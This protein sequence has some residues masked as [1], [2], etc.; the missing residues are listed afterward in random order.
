MSTVKTFDRVLKVLA[1]NYADAFL[2][3]ALPD[4]PLKLAG[5]LENVELSIPEERVDF[6]HRVLRGKQ[7]YLLHI[8]FQ[9]THR[10]DVPQ[11]LFVYSALL[12]KQMDT[13]VITIVIYLTPRGKSLPES[14]DVAVDDLVLNRFEYQVVRLWEYR[15][16]I[17]AGRWPELAPL[18]AMLTPEPD[19]RVLARE[20]ELILK[21]SDRRKRADLLACAVTIGTRYFDREFLWRFFREEVEMMKEATFIDDWLQE[22]LNEGLTRGRLE[23]LQEGLQVGYRDGQRDTSRSILRRVLHMRFGEVMLPLDVEEKLNLLPPSQLEALIYEA[24][25]ASDE[26]S[27]FQAVREAGGVAMQQVN[28]DE[29]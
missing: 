16:E 5:T 26:E 18:L 20:R 8:E 10:A 7:E 14:Y 13:P 2:R 17:E 28:W 22:K 1:R 6:V 29:E 9:V 12:T 25:T 3:L 4:V 19:A 11:R 27:F 24:M 23:G 21:E 15:E